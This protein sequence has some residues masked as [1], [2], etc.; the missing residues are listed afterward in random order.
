MTK[1]ERDETERLINTPI[2]LR[3]QFRGARVVSHFYPVHWA[4]VQLARA[5]REA[6]SVTKTPKC[7]SIAHTPSEA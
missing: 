3:S 2:A 7:S 5:T 4:R 1:P 6:W